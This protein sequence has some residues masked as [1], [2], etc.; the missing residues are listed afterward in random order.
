M[1]ISTPLVLL[2]LF[3]SPACMTP[4]QEGAL[5][6]RAAVG[7]QQQMNTVYFLDLGDEESNQIAV[8]RT[9]FRPTAT[10]NMECWATLRNRTDHPWQLEVQASFFD[11]YEAPVESSDGWRRLF[12][13]PRQSGSVTIA[14]TRP[15]APNGA[16]SHYV[17]QVRAGR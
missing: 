14:S 13:A 6:G 16:V 10:G 5:P 4:H 2:S 8:E 7:F 17:L 9:G 12:L 1:K 15:L 3:L 11:E